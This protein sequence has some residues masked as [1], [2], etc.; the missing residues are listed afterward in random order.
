M[1]DAQIIT[2]KY[3]GAKSVETVGQNSLLIRKFYVD[4]TTNPDY[5][6]TP[7]FRLM[8]D[9][10]SLVD[11]LQ[12]GQTIQIRYNIDGRKF[13]NREGKEGVITNLT[14]WKIEVIQVH[15]AAV[16]PAQRP[17]AQPAAVAPVAARS[18]AQ[19]V[20]AEVPFAFA[21]QDDDLPF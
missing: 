15:S 7:E 8:G 16:A 13:T 14:A 3:L 6:N 21:G 11:N 17:V 10:V 5:P 1:Q 4:I 18:T 20:A 9:R 19:S 2:G 12:K